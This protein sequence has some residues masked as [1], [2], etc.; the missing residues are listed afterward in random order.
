MS[1]KLR[2]AYVDRSVNS[3]PCPCRTY[4]LPSGWEEWQVL[5]IVSGV[6]TW[7][8]LPSQSETPSSNSSSPTVVED[9]PNEE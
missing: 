7:T 4:V 1:A 9:L 6:P 3:S 5:M 8:T 2:G